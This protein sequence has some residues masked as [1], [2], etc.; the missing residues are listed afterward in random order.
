MVFFMQLTELALTRVA[1]ERP[2]DRVPVIR[3]PQLVEAQVVFA[4]VDLERV[5]ALMFLVQVVYKVDTQLDM[6][7]TLVFH[8]ELL[9]VRGWFPVPVDTSLPPACPVQTY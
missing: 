8:G 9:W 4:L 2:G 1:R 3:I 5:A 6:L 7:L